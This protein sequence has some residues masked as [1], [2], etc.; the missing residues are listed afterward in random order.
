[1]KKIGLMLALL[2]SCS[3]LFAKGFWEGKPYSNWSKKEVSKM[4]NDS[5]WAKDQVVR[6]V[7]REVAD[8]DRSGSRSGGFDAPASAGEPGTLS[9]ERT[10]VPTGG[11]SPSS[12]PSR[13]FF[14]RFQSATPVR[15]AIACYALLNQ[16]ANAEQAEQYVDTPP[17][18]GRIVISLSVTGGEGPS[19]L[20]SLSTEML[21]SIAYL[22]LKKSKKKIYLEQYVSPQEVGGREAL[23][24]FPRQQNG[25]DLISLKEKEIRFILTLDEQT[26]LNR[27]FKLKDMIF[28]GK[29]EI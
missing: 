3:L 5:P 24:I 11:A 28:D 2:L 10:P 26:R 20:D 15:M 6:S 29:L 18:D 9:R 27:K 21:K 17:Y 1:M 7:Q 14:V 25:E 23:L 16:Q 13:Q 8:P 12:G 22:Q 19:G 4:L